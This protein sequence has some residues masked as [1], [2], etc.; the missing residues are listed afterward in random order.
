[1]NDFLYNS[2]YF[3][4]NFAHDLSFSLLVAATHLYLIHMATATDEMTTWTVCHLIDLGY[5]EALAYYYPNNTHNGS[6]SNSCL[7][8]VP[9]LIDRPPCSLFC[10]NLTVSIKY[11]Q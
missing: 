8:T 4:L 1:M 10:S 2:S 7:Y 11:M 9:L 3:A 6:S 5:C